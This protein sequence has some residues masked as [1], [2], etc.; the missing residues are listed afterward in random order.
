MEILT[1]YNKIGK[2]M[3]KSSHISLLQIISTH[4][5]G[6][7]I[8]LMKA[9]C[10]GSISLSPTF[11]KSGRNSTGTWSHF[12]SLKSQATIHIALLLAS[13]RETSWSSSRILGTSLPA[14]SYILRISSPVNF[15][16]ELM[17]LISIWRILSFEFSQAGIFCTSGT[18]SIPK[19]RTWILIE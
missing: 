8:C 19:R 18:P 1:G 5:F 7:E 4:S 16:S 2:F 13:S 15:S 11:S 14:S 9:V 6:K 3:I 10:L 17:S 12:V